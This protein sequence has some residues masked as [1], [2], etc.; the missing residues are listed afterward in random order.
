M[1]NVRRLIGLGNL[2]AAAIICGSVMAAETPYYQ[3]KTV[4]VIEARAA[5]GTGSL[6]TQTAMK[7]LS[8]HLPGNP[9]VVYQYMS[10]GGGAIAMNHLANVA[11]KDG[12]TIGNVSSGIFAALITGAPSIR[13]KLEEIRWLGSGTSGT[14]TA[15]VVR[16]GLGIDSVEKLRAYKGLRF[17]NRSVGHSMYIRDRLTAF[18]VELKEPRWI[19]G[20]SDQE[21]RLALERG[22]AD[23][24]FGGIAGHV[25]EA[26]DWFQKGF[27]VPVI[28]KNGKGEGAERYPDFPQGRPGVDEFADT[29]IKKA[30]LAIYH[31]TNSGS[32]FFVHRDIPEPARKALNDA[33]NKMWKD[34]EYAKEHERLTNEAADP[35]T[36]DEIHAIL[37]Q[38]PKDAKIIDV[39]KQLIGGGTL[40]PSK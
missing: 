37:A 36:G 5:G 34:P 27:T 20:Y 24:Q 19:L 12:L 38:V 28:L 22:E 23:A 17:G 13:F 16:P 26:K 33:F 4:T 6:R 30:M 32:V 11:R 25:R 39:Y 9:A 14:P 1:A 8:K 10:G 2:L 3:G 29:E 7:Y 40:P 35:T 21:I 18:I 31:A 15:L